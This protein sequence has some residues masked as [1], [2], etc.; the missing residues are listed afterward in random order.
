MRRILTILAMGFAVTALSCD[1]VNT[2]GGNS[3][4]M[5]ARS[6]P[7]GVTALH[8]AVYQGFAE[9]ENLLS[10]QVFY[11]GQSVSMNVPGGGAR[12]FVVWGEGSGGTAA[13]YGTAGPVDVA[14]DGEMDVSV[15]M[16][17]FNVNADVFNLF[18]NTGTNLYTWNAVAG[19]SIYELQTYSGMYAYYTAYSGPGTSYKIGT[20][21]GSGR[22]R[23]YSTLFNLYSDYSVWGL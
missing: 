6:F 9:E 18:R 1:L 23:V 5:L 3:R 8:V 20:W 4:V 10:Y 15:S 12:V 16:V 17:K 21:Y 11:P 7:P 19:A 14:S 22:V 13:Y 2:E